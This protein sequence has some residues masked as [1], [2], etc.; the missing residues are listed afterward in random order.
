M[1]RRSRLTPLVQEVLCAHLAAGAFANAAC[2]AAG[3]SETS[4]YRWLE[5]GRNSSSGRYRELWEAVTRA[6]A[7]AVTV[8]RAYFILDWR[9][10]KR[11][12]SMKVLVPACPPPAIRHFSATSALPCQLEDWS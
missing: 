5:R 1:S 3:V 8:W 12:A 4:Y 2:A 11:R 9:A 10:A 6:R 7:A